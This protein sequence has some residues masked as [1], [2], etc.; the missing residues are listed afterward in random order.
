MLFLLGIIT[1]KSTILLHRSHPPI[2]NPGN[3]PQGLPVS[4]GHEK[5]ESESVSFF[6]P[7]VHFM[8]LINRIVSKD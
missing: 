7:L 8:R 4:V 6:L 2:Q 3:I 5:I 1:L